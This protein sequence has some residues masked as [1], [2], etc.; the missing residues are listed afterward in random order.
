MTWVGIENVSGKEEMQ[1]SRT[2]NGYLSFQID[3]DD[4]D[5]GVIISTD[6]IKVLNKGNEDKFKLVVPETGPHAMPEF[7]FFQDKDHTF[8]VTHRV[9]DVPTHTKPDYGIGDWYHDIQRSWRDYYTYTPI[10]DPEG[11]IVNPGRNYTDP[12]PYIDEYFREPQE[13]KVGIKKAAVQEKTIEFKTAT[14]IIHGN[15]GVNVGATE[16]TIQPLM[17]KSAN[18]EY[19]ISSS[20]QYEVEPEIK[21]ISKGQRLIKK[22]T[23]EHHFTFTTF[24]HYH[25]KTFI[26]EL[27]K[28]GIEGLLK[29]SVETQADTILFKKNYDP[30]NLVTKPYPT[31]EV[32]FVYGSA[33]SQYN[34]ELFF[35]VPMLI[36]CRLKD[37]QRFEEARDWFHYIFDPTQ[38]E[39][40]DKERFWQFKP[41]FDEAGTQ[42]ATLDDLLKNE[43]EL[44]AQVDKWMK[45]PFMPHV[46]ARMRISAYMRN[47]VMKYLDNIIAWGDN[48]FRRDTIEAINEATNLYIMAAKILGERPQ[49]I[50]PRA[51]HADASFDD[52]K[53]ELD[54]FSNAMVAIE[55]MLAPSSSS[56]SGSGSSNALG[57]MF[58]FCVPRNEFLM[59]YWDTVADRLFKIRNSMNTQGIVRTLPLFEPPID[60]AMLVRAAAAGM[61]LSSI[62]SDL[63][64][65]LPNYRF[66]FMLQKALEF[67]N[68]VK[69][70][71]SALLQALEK[72]DAA[73]S[74][75]RSVHEQKMLNVV[76]E[77]EGKGGRC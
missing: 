55:T 2:K 8:Y 48:L 4:L 50:P 15:E 45:N 72:R 7:F 44:A 43:T 67:S 39:G 21:L 26:K 14:V 9:V 37:D 41:F 71:G 35:H 42:I 49:Q 54:S 59:K 68:E 16:S 6:H 56:G 34:W 27:Y 51:E 5:G 69:S 64:A 63:N 70:L 74:L 18:K 66:N 36:A 75:L 61:D 52:I 57:E 24:Y 20:Y 40:G 60:P 3:H 25:V 53:D 17:M 11:P 12:I 46:I 33:Y 13:I 73:F 65:A 38:S 10:E 47:V 23:E 76:L 29:R 62:L 30:T 31:S 77:Y 28:L 1:V 22:Y 19:G 32:D 58:Y